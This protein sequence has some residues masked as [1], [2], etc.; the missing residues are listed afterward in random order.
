MATQKK[1]KKPAAGKPSSGSD[2]KSKRIVK[3]K[4]AEVMDEFKHGQLESGNSS[5]KVK[6]PKQAIAIGLSEARQAG[7]EL[8][9]NPNAKKNAAKKKSTAAKKQP[10]A[11]KTPKKSAANKK[12]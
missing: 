11:T 4:M 7:A 9:P 10:P 5:K 6:N 1:T 2:P 12:S 3:R 8:P